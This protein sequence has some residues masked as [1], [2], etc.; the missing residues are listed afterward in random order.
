MQNVEA[1]GVFDLP[2]YLWI[3]YQHV[4]D[5]RILSGNGIMEG[6]IT[7]FVLKW[8]HQR[9]V[10][11]SHPNIHHNELLVNDLRKIDVGYIWKFLLA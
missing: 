4:D 6:G 5:D 7:L 1:F 2:I 3:V 11:L 9:Y 8:C 10:Y